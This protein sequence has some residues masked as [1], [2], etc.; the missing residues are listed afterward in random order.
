MQGSPA[1][2]PK[3][4]ALPATI[5]IGAGAGTDLGVELGAAKVAVHHLLPLPPLHR[6][7]RD[8]QQS[9][10]FRRTRD[11]CCSMIWTSTAISSTWQMHC[12]KLEC[13]SSAGHRHVGLPAAA[14]CRCCKQICGICWRRLM[15]P[16]VAAAAAGICCCH[17][18]RCLEAAAAWV[19][20]PAQPSAG[21]P[22]LRGQQ[23]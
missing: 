21:I 13:R 19:T 12:Q 9:G 1:C 20:T 10:K 17:C 11:S 8:T 23:R 5:V 22:A 18:N 4:R 14:T 7:G 3:L 16:S 15:E 6:Y 2:S